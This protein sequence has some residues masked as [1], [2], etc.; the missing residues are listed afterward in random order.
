MLSLQ[1]Y[2]PAKLSRYIKSFWCLR[3]S[4]TGG[5]WY[6]EDILPDGHHEIIFHLNTNGA[7]R[8]SE[9]ESWINEPASFFAGQ[10]VKTYS[11]E[12]KDDSMLYGIRFFPHTMAPLFGFPADQ[13]TNSILALQN[14]PGAGFLE[15][16]ITENAAETF[17]NFEQAISKKINQQDLSSNAFQ[18]VDHSV[19]E[20]MKHKG[21]IRIDRLI[22][23]GGISQKYFDTLFRQFIGIN[24]KTFCNIIKLNHFIGYRNNNPGKTLTECAYEANFFDQSH[25]IKLFKSVTGKSPKDYFRADNHH[26]N[27]YFS[28]L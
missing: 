15:K 1:T 2:K 19:L 20:I 6:E 21:D 13:V 18:Y 3:I 11:L 14:I 12:L 23:A 17:S 25:L 22:R 16:N 28:A 4:G 27:N 8:K 26:I 10:T 5:N 7:K 9:N 24:P